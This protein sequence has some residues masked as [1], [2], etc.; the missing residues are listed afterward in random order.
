[1]CLGIV[2][3]VC[4]SAESCLKVLFVCCSLWR[5]ER[6]ENFLICMPGSPAAMHLSC[7]FIKL[8]CIKSLVRLL[9]LS[10]P[11]FPQCPTPSPLPLCGSMSLQRCGFSGELLKKPGGMLFGAG[12]IDCPGIRLPFYYKPENRAAKNTTGKK[13]E[14][15]TSNRL[16]FVLCCAFSFIFSSACLFSGLVNCL[17]AKHLRQSQPHSTS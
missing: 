1:M 7:I 8:A 6:R 3:V 12:V 10:A 11:V 15:N 2:C 16:T 13:T 17:K 14:R 5:S 4:V 9:L